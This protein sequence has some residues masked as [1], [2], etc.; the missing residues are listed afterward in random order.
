MVK[1]MK[2][3]FGVQVWA[4]GVKIEPQTTFFVTFASSVH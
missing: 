1:F 3:F 2:Q 4:K